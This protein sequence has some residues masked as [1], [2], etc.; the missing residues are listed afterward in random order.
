M[1]LAAWNYPTGVNESYGCKF[2]YKKDNSAGTDERL[3][4]DEGANY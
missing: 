2:L 4:K 3:Q 1:S